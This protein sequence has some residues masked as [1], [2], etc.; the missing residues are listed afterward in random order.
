[1][2]WTQLFT[3]PTIEEVDPPQAQSEHQAGALL[4]DVREPH[5][6]EAGHAPGARLIPLGQLS[7]E[8][9]NLPRTGEI[10]FMC[11]SGSRSGR[12]T[13]IAGQAG[14]RAKN[15]RGGM[16]SWSRHGLPVER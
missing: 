16:I 14:L 9:P 8:I 4:V 12:A 13:E 5:E 15:V 1:M 6:Y 7:R 2:N 3:R 10:L 11:R